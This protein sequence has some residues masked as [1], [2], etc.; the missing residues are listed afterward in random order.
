M[1]IHMSMYISMHIYTQMSTHMFQNAWNPPAWDPRMDI[2]TDSEA[3]ERLDRQ[4]VS[5]NRGSTVAYN[6]APIYP[7]APGYRPASS[8]SRVQACL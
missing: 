4:L 3:I 2:E 8:G 6:G 7:V 5:Y 1:P